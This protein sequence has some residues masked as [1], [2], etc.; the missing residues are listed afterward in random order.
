MHFWVLTESL[1]LPVTSWESNK[2]Q[3]DILPNLIFFVFSILLKDEFYTLLD[4]AKIKHIFL[5][6]IHVN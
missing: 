4:N 3:L 6:H 5:I 1:R 2:P